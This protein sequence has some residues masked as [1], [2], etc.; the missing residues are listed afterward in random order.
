MR[1]PSKLLRYR[2]GLR[3]TDFLICRECGTYVA[4]LHTADASSWATLNVNTFDV[5]DGFPAHPAVVFY[6]GESGPERAARRA[7]RWTPVREF[8]IPG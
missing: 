7:Q 3:M 1:D 2:F 5:Q 4:A 6:E 8:D